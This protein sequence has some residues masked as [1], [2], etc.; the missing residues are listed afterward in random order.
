MAL[1]EL[2]IKTSD[3]EATDL[4][5]RERE[6]EKKPSNL[7]PLN[8]KEPDYETPKVP[9]TESKPAEPTKDKLTP[10]LPKPIAPEE[11]PDKF[12]EEGTR[13]TVQ[14]EVLDNDSAKLI[15]GGTAVPT[16]IGLGSGWSP[17]IAQAL[18]K[19]GLL[20]QPPGGWDE[21]MR[22]L[23]EEGNVISSS[24]DT[25]EPLFTL[26]GVTDSL[27]SIAETAGKTLISVPETA[28]HLITATP[29][30]LIGGASG[31]RDAGVEL[32]MNENVNVNDAYN[33]FTKGVKRGLEAT[34]A[35]TYDPVYKE[36]SDRLLKLMFMPMEGYHE[37][38][39]LIEDDY[40]NLA[41][42]TRF[43]ADFVGLFFLHRVTSTAKKPFTKPTPEQIMS[44]VMAEHGPK[45]KQ[46]VNMHKI[47][48]ETPEGPLK[49]LVQ[50]ELD[51]AMKR[52]EAQLKDAPVKKVAKVE[53]KDLGRRKKK[54]EE[55]R[56]G[57][58]KKV[59][60][61]EPATMPEFEF[62]SK[63]GNRYEKRGDKWYDGEG[64][65][66]KN[67]FVIK[68]AERGKVSVE[69]KGEKVEPKPVM[70]DELPTDTRRG[71]E[72]TVE[73]LGDVDGV[74][75]F[76]KG[77]TIVDRYAREYARRRFGEDIK[78]REAEVEPVETEIKT[79]Q[80]KKVSPKT[81]KQKEL[82]KGEV[83]EPSPLDNVEA[84]KDPLD[85]TFFQDKAQAE[86]IG[87]M[88]AN[89][90]RNIYAD[91]QV[92]TQR[93][94]NDVNR[95]FH[96]DDSIPIDKVRSALDDLAGQVDRLYDARD[97]YGEEFFTSRADWELWKRTVEDAATWAKR[98]DRSKIERTVKSPEEA[99]IADDLARIKE[100]EDY[101]GK[102][103][104]KITDQEVSKFYEQKFKKAT[105]PTVDLNMMVPLDGLPK[106]V[107]D[108][109][110]AAG[111]EAKYFKHL[112]GQVEFKE[113]YRNEALWKKTGFW[114]DKDGRW[115]Y[116]I[117]EDINFKVDPSDITHYDSIKLGDLINASEFFKKF[118]TFKE[119]PVNFR[120]L[121]PAVKGQYVYGLNEI[122]L[123]RIKFDRPKR[124]LE[125]LTHEL[126]HA[127]EYREGTKFEGTNI[128]Y[129]YLKQVYGFFNDLRRNAKSPELQKLVDE[130]KLKYDR[131]R[132]LSR[133]VPNAQSY[134][135]IISNATRET[136]KN[137]RPVFEEAFQ[138][139]FD[140]STLARYMK[141]PGEML[142]RVNSVRH[143][144][145]V[146]KRRKTPPWKTLD[147]ML[148]KEKELKPEDVRAG[149]NT[150]FSGVDPT[151]LAKNIS[152]GIKKVDDYIDRAWNAKNI[153]LKEQA[154]DLIRTLKTDWVDRQGNI[155][156]QLVKAMKEK[157]WYAIVKAG[158][159][160]GASSKSHHEL[161]QLRRDVYDGLSR[162]KRKVF[163]GLMLMDRLAKIKRAKGKKF[164]MPEGLTVKQ[165]EQWFEHKKSQMQM[166]DAE[167]NDLLKRK[168]KYYAAMQ[169]PLK[170]LHDAELISDKL[171]EDLMKNDYR[172]LELV[173][174]I[175]PKRTIGKGDSKRSVRDSGI[176]YLQRGKRSD[177]FDMDSEL[178]ASEVFNR[179][180]SR[181][182]NNKAN[183]TLRELAVEDPINPFVR[184]K[185]KGTP[186]P[187]D[188]APVEFFV[189]G[190]K[191]KLY[192]SPLMQSEW[193]TTT[194][195]LGETAARM[196][197]GLRFWS[198]S[199]LVRGLAT[200]Y[201]VGFALNN[202]PRDV[203]HSFITSQVYNPN[204]GRFQSLWSP[205]LPVAT[206][207]MARDYIS[208]MPD[209]VLR[210]GRYKDYV[211]EGG[212]MQFLTLYGRRSRTG[213]VHRGKV[214][215]FLE[216]M[217]YIGETSEI[218]TRLA[219]REMALRKYAKLYDMPIEQA[220]KDPKIRDLA[221]FAARDY[222]DFGQGGRVAKAIDHGVPYFN[223]GIQA[224]RGLLRAAKTNP[225][226]FA[227]KTAQFGSMVFA[228]DQVNRHHAPEGR[229]NV[230]DEERKNNLIIHP[231]DA[232][233]K[234]IDHE[235]QE[236]YWYIKI[237]IDQTMRWAKMLFEGI[238]AKYNDEEFDVDN[239]VAGL[240]EL[241]PWDPA[242][243]VL[244][245]AD[246]MVSY[247]LNKDMWTRKDLWTGGKMEKPGDEYKPLK[248]PVWSKHIG[249][250]TGE[251]VSPRRIQE[252]LSNVAPKNPLTQAFGAA[253]ENA[254]SD[255]PKEVRQQHWLTAL[256]Q[257]P[258]VER[259]IGT[260]HPYA[261]YAEDVE[262]TEAAERSRRLLLDNEYSI[263]VAGHL[264][265]PQVVSRME[266][267]KFINSIPNKY[268]RKRLRERFETDLALSK[269]SEKSF[270]RRI[271][272]VAPEVRARVFY[273]HFGELP[274][275]EQAKIKSELEDV[276]GIFGE[277]FDEEVTRLRIEKFGQK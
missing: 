62:V 78:V 197:E 171:Y 260:T 159:S 94:I 100:L 109:L 216:A 224:G 261:K 182:Y 271:S 131:A 22:P 98:L 158:L 175:D 106:I 63:K 61:V 152:K 37:I 11:E 235:G 269:V 252:A 41:G 240:S 200:G 39:N 117:I 178:M 149:Q 88:Y 229:R 4:L 52:T 91:P 188:W 32:L 95:W 7:T 150:L 176:D 259:I 263:K 108:L 89:R 40:P 220:K 27:K 237:S 75:N 142:A 5:G 277:R 71:V 143:N 19:S 201:N 167:W 51:I 74:D 9:T 234:Y 99:T 112:M 213:Q 60:K 265:D 174:K 120:D 151:G 42:A 14:K 209:S 80:R 24:I 105:K 104:D 238:S 102:D 2:R 12:T 123:N 76:Y 272:G 242:T 84:T 172:R 45:V 241:S 73:E 245:I 29:G 132:I 185:K 86:E 183:Q 79:K 153:P 38:A 35:V 243:V 251:S 157:G 65:E 275:I 68:A 181:I 218:I 233:G 141:D 34:K 1:Q 118:P 18:G 199:S 274:L 189:K 81:E 211:D 111:K 253:Y 64:K 249:Q 276:K 126:Q 187:K 179:A 226:E 72:R 258:L 221:T 248:D 124:V 246:A 162:K 121:P 66:V 82:E 223:A 239:F 114:L 170:A 163:E 165:I 205:H 273:K 250:L 270:W 125:T 28:A 67:N 56:V 122:D 77:D 244:P 145:S 164:V 168:D 257:T 156:P 46:I 186:V 115:R 83:N 116:E 267:M 30:F 136:Y 20:P 217:G 154:V 196:A 230:S 8:I 236:R 254:F 31:L 227:Y 97:R 96:G 103:I 16:P 232:I 146:A 26:E 58:E 130:V 215:T 190:K 69:G 195:G 193:V 139:S 48:A 47:N 43:F 134:I 17:E 93:L 147:D 256:G 214:D 101:F 144:M 23:D 137:E 210:R 166:S 247:T 54:F 57:K 212:G 49:T 3:T 87:R 128:N 266:M 173:N 194:L 177:L 208:V 262:E 228:L 219:N 55:A 192:L 155:R 70:G 169:K 135:D 36:E 206:A 13:K 184:I 6:R 268:D 255:V 59:A 113:L 119:M 127:I 203:L 204:T 15:Y 231:P 198:G 107:K 50:K 138:K 53:G 160:R 10:I 191:E 21:L 225:K 140:S 92:M 33:I 129:E 133:D 90:S 207:Q 44:E 148:R 25:G 161:A 202:L 85:S 264:S 110:R 222:L 180:Y